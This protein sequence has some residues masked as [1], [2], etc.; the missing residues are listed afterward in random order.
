[1]TSC[2]PFFPYS[3][4]KSLQHT[5]QCWKLPPSWTFSSHL[6]DSTLVQHKNW[7]QKIL[8]LFLYISCSHTI[9][10]LLHEKK[11]LLF[12]L[13]G[14]DKTPFILL[15][16]HKDTQCLSKWVTERQKKSIA[17]ERTPSANWVNFRILC[18]VSD[19]KAHH[20]HCNPIL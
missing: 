11:H 15:T 16:G 8:L 1:M 18:E 13:H 4:I 3:S 7:K 12:H 17:F 20:K 19:A 9:V 14:F 5:V 10:Y 2:V 6:A